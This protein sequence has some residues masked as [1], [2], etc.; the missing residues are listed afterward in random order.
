MAFHNKREM[1]ASSGFYVS[2]TLLHNTGNGKDDLMFSLNSS[3]VD[4]K[5]NIL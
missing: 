2:P 4:G 1:N 3:E 5:E